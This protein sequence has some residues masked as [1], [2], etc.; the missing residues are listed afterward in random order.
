[1]FVVGKKKQKK[2]SKGKQLFNNPRQSYD[3]SAQLFTVSI[4]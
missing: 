2:S 1:M 4:S 3:S